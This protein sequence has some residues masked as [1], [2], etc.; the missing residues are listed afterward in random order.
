MR[1]ELPTWLVVVIIVVAIVIVGAIF[2]R[3]TRP[4]PEIK[5]TPEMERQ[6]QE[7]MERAFREGGPA[8][9]KIVPSPYAPKKSPQGQ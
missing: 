3:A 9:G 8:G 2:W 4:A 6:M 1:K 7:A 5:E